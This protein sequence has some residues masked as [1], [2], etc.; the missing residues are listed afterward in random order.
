MSKIINLRPLV[1]FFPLVF[2]SLLIY[3]PLTHGANGANT[4]KQPLDMSEKLATSQ[5]PIHITADRME[6]NQDENTITF[7]SHVVV[8]QDDVTVTSNR[9]KVTM[10]QGDKTPASVES[11]PAERIDYIEFEGDVKVTQQDRLATAKKAI[12]YQKEQK[13]MLHGRPVVTKGQDRV[14]GDLIT[15]YLKEGRSV[16]EGGAGAPVQAVLFPGK[17]E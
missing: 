2:V 14:E 3:C 5:S 7:E 4:S 15:I 17:K 10:L 6:T 11:T 1:S 13:I 16:V 12:F 8:Q 9:L